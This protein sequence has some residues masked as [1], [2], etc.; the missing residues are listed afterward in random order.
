MVTDR[1]RADGPAGLVLADPEANEFCVLR[2]AGER[3]KTTTV[4]DQP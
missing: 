3:V 2:T 4:E 1:R